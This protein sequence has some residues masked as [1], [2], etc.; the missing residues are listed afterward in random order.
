MYILVVELHVR[1]SKSAHVHPG[2]GI[3]CEGRNRTQIHSCSLHADP[4]PL[5]Q[6]ELA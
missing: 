3:A 5:L 4:P 2:G 1:G 6:G